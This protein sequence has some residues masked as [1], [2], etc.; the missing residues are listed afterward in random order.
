[1]SSQISP[2][3]ESTSTFNRWPHRLELREGH[4][5]KDFLCTLFKALDAYAIRYCVLHSWEELPE[6]LWSDL[7]LGM[8]PQDID[9]LPFVFHYLREHEYRVVQVFNYFVNAY[10]FV[11]CWQE[12][13]IVTWTAVDV[14]FEHRRGGLVVP[15]GEA[16]VFGRRRKGIFWIPDAKPEFSYLLSK[17]IWKGTCPDRQARRLR[18]LVGELGRPVADGLASELLLGKSSRRLVDACDRGDVNEQFARAKDHTWITSLVRNP[19]KLATHLL[20]DT[21]R[22]LQRWL[23]PTGLLLVVAG[24]DGAGKSTLIERLVQATQPAF[25]RSRIFHWRP[26]L[27]WRSKSTRDTTQPHGCTVHGVSWSV[28]R[29]F[30]YLLDYWVGYLILVRPLLARS[31]LVVFDRYFDDMWIDP[32]RY[33]YGGPV[34]LTRALRQFIPRPDLTIVLDADEGVLIARKEELPRPEL[35]RQRAL[36]RSLQAGSAVVYVIDASAPTIEVEDKSIQAILKYLTQR[37]D[38]RH[39]R[40]LRLVRQSL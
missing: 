7:D 17:K 24:P 13:S 26:M 11:F 14:I 29:L 28:L 5:H 27:L 21:A 36:Y 34:W 23:Q 22:R 40:W 38:R 9:K 2:E 18:A 32:K 16:L 31:G 15:S 4:T 3:T 33:R 25:R 8:H 37:F 30:A 19:L 35:S 6:K 10:Y 20:S 12:G 39:K 1:M